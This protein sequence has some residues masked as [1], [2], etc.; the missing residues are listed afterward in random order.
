MNYQESLF[1]KLH[2]KVDFKAILRSD[3]CKLLSCWLDYGEP[4]LSCQHHWLANSSG[5]L[6]YANATFPM[7]LTQ[8]YIDAALL[9][10]GQYNC[11]IMGV[12]GKEWLDVGI[13]KHSPLF[14]LKWSINITLRSEIAD[15]TKAYIYGRIK[16]YTTSFK[17]REHLIAILEYSLQYLNHHAWEL[18]DTV[19][20]IR[21]ATF[22]IGPGIEKTITM[23]LTSRK[24]Y[25]KRIRASKK[26]LS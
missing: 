2:P 5:I 20:G 19:P 23:L 9:N 3:E 16:H 1:Y 26:A 11:R 7:E 17:A 18:N 10:H 13:V 6:K 25:C 12:K 8:P 4:T 21:K 15:M 14:H 22:E 24:Q